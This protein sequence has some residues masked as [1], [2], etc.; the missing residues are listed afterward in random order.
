MY[1]S[2]L[3]L[4]PHVVIIL[5]HLNIYI[6]SLTY[7][8]TDSLLLCAE[9]DAEEWCKLLCVECLGTRL[10]D[11]SL[12]EPDLLAAGVQREQNGECPISPS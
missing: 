4:D 9:L 2:T 1:E 11:I 8:C 10:N 12:G 5:L 6:H 7:N 3:R